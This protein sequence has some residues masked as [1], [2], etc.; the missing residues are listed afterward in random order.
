VHFLPFS[1]HSIERFCSYDVGIQWLP[2]SRAYDRTALNSSECYWCCETAGFS[3]VYKMNRFEW[4]SLNESISSLGHCFYTNKRE[5]SQRQRKWRFDL[6]S[7]VL[8]RHISS[9]RIGWPYRQLSEIWMSTLEYIY[10]TLSL[11]TFTCV[12]AR[13]SRPGMCIR[14]VEQYALRSGQWF[15][16]EIYVISLFRI[17]KVNLFSAH[18]NRSQSLFW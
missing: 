7:R 3:W 14:W 6:P 8:S 18:Y 2:V 9:N 13:N 12:T 5:N 10:S 16:F 11:V 17:G 4:I 15:P 1:R